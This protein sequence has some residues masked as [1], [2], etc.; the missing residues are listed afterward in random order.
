MT[1]FLSKNKKQLV[2][3][4]KELVC[5]YCKRGGFIQLHPKHLKT[6]DITVGGRAAKGAIGV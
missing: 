4:E 1:T 2:T 5:P 6:H 3:D